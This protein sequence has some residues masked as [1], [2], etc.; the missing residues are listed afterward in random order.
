MQSTQ[1]EKVVCSGKAYTAGGEGE[2]GERR[3]ERSSNGNRTALGFTRY[4]IKLGIGRL[5]GGCAACCSHSQQNEAGVTGETLEH[6]NC[7]QLQS[8]G[9]ASEYRKDFKLL[10]MNVSAIRSL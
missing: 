7:I 10:I 3:A 1:R 6:Y 4:K 9:V 2:S 8:G 5:V